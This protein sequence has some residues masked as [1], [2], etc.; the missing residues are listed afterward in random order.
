MSSIDFLR[1]AQRF[2]VG[3]M[4]RLGPIKTRVADRDGISYTEF[5]YQILQAYDWLQLVQRYSCSVQVQQSR[6]EMPSRWCRVAIEWFADRRF[7]PT[8]SLRRG[9][10]LHPEALP[11]PSRLRPVPSPGRGRLREQAG[12]VVHGRD[13]RRV[14]QRGED[15]A[16]CL[17]SVLATNARSIRGTST[18]L[19][20]P[21][22]DAGSPRISDLLHGISFDVCRSH[23]F[24]SSIARVSASG[25]HNACSRM[26]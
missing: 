12:Q 22:R 26:R 23:R 19:F 1:M 4:L 9:L 14:A 18:P 6:V 10:P 2:R 3:E 8:G 13:R 15:V 24:S 16:V 21:P 17:L 5:S 25:W 11:L 20:L 7:G